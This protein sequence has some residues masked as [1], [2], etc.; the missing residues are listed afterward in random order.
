ARDDVAENAEWVIH[1]ELVGRAVIRP[2]SRTVEIVVGRAWT[3]DDVGVQQGDE[4]DGR[5]QRASGIADRDGDRAQVAA[6]Q[7]VRHRDVEA[8]RDEVGE[9]ATIHVVAPD[10]NV[11]LDVRRAI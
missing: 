9:R 7:A 6:V 5:K 10:E 4:G 2:R 3:T 8:L 11:L 1:L